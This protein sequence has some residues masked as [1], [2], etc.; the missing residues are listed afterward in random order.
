MSGECDS[1]G[2]HI[3]DCICNSEK[4][5]QDATKHI[6]Q[7]F[8][9]FLW[10]LDDHKNDWKSRDDLEDVIDDFIKEFIIKE[11]K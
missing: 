5:Y 10:Y 1:C 9:D 4:K 11:E 3:V 6:K 8:L 7:M 2:E